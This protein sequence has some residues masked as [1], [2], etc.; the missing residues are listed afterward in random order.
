MMQQDIS[1][2]YSKGWEDLRKQARKLE[3]EIDLK[4]V[5][6]SKLGTGHTGIKP[7]SDTEPLLSTEHVF[8]T[9][10]LDV[11]QLLTQLTAVN[12]RLAEVSA[13]D[14]P[15]APSN[16][17]LIHT[18]QRHK[19]ILQDYKQEFSKTKANWRARRE[20]EDLLRSVR[21][22]ID[23]YKSS[24]GLNRRMDMYLKENEHIRSSDRLVDEQISIAVDTR[25]NLMSQ[26]LNFKRIQTR[27]HDLS[28]RFPAVNSL[29][30][31]INLRKRRDSLILGSIVGVCTFL[32]LLYAFH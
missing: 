2:G 17:A 21:K 18:L 8:E 27:M 22:D 28:S 20:R 13:P 4:L 15:S 12:E 24:S 30:Q 1:S 14:S 23:T 26:R 29:I 6:F 31:R 32:M 25:E 11:E 9:M 10:A 5:S 7:D 3:N 16:A 19:E